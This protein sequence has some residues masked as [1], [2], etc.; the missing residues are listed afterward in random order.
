VGCAEEASIAN[1]IINEF[2]TRTK[3]LYILSLD[4]RDAFSRIPHDLIRIKMQ[5]VS[6]PEEIRKVIMNTYENAY[7]NIISKDGET[8]KVQIKKRLKQGCPLSL[9]HFNLG[10]DPLLRYLNEQFKDYGYNMNINNSKTMNVT[11]TIGHYQKT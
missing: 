3:Q 10:I 9:T 6:I 7:I 1:L 8:D 5:K 11:Q 4:L 2:L